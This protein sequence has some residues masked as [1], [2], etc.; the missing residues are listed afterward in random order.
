MSCFSYHYPNFLWRNSLYPTAYN[1]ERMENRYLPARLVQRI[2]S[3]IT[4]L[5]P[6]DSQV[7]VPSS[8]DGNSRLGLR[9]WK[10][11]DRGSVF[12]TAAFWPNS[13]PGDLLP[14]SQGHS[15]PDLFQTWFSILQSILGA[16]KGFLIN[17]S[18]LKLAKSV[19]VPYNQTTLTDL[20]PQKIMGRRKEN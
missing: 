6:L 3:P 9:I 7:Q 10:T 14:A 5:F 18:W 16:P 2:R 13:P 19:S 4:P 15:V 17:S 12:L 1:S 20:C 8:A 11:S